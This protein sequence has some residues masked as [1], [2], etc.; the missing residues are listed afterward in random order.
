MTALLSVLT[1]LKL[2]F[3]GA[4]FAVFWSYVG[5]PL[6]LW[7]LA[8]RRRE[9]P[10]APPTAG[11]GAVLPSVSIIVA[12]Y[13]E[14][15]HIAAKLDNMLALAYP[16]ELLQ[17]IVASDCS[18]DNTHAIAE[19]Y[20]GRGVELSVLPTRGGKTAAQNLA[21]TR[22][23]G[24]IVVFTD[25]TTEFAPETL[26]DLLTPFGRPEVGCVGAELEYVSVQGSVV[27]RGAGAYWRYEKAVKALESRVHSLIGVS[28][29]LYAVRRALYRPME[30]ALIS[31]F[32]IAGDVYEQGAITVGARGAVSREATNE[33]T[34]REF[35]MRVRVAVRSINALVTRA[36]L[37]NPL[38]FG[39]FAY[40]LWSHKVL[41][42]AA[43]HLLLLATISALLIVSIEGGLT[44]YGAALSVAG[45]FV[46]A[47]LVGWRVA[48][49]KARVPLVHIPFYFVHV[50]FAALW[51][52]VLYLRGERKV[53][54]TTVRT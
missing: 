11:A 3:W 52:S 46:L 10:T 16:P 33:S 25:A 1:L 53:T 6:H 48:T 14:E 13:N 17:V 38:R 21:V 27:G 39:F 49:G 36:R 24:D 22:A 45:V 40:Q 31:D 42:Y 4:L 5:Y 41:R 50:N 23:R 9:V 35:D 43:P 44:I 28:G 26:H 34:D 47:A 8:R 29:C 30:P 51:A 20:A 15:R 32:M 19:G 37:L 7:L 12:A 18:T 2:L 54:W